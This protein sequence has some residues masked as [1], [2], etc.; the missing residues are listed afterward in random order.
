[1]MRSLYEIDP[2]PECPELVRVIVEIPKNAGNKYEYDRKLGV[3]RLD[4]ALYSPMHYPGDYGFIP[5]TLAPDGDPMDVLVMV[6][7][8][9][10][11]GCM[12]EVR[13]VGILNMIDQQASDQKILAVPNR[14]P[15]YDE[16]HTMDQIFPHVRREIEHFFTIYKELEGRVTT[17]QGWD[18][19]REARRAIQESRTAY[20][21]KQ[22]ASGSK[23]VSSD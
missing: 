1:M 21:E 16:V 20:L 2:G 8:P 15:R 19:P 7:E 13:P 3:F 17:T 5:G 11:P 6:E 22:R 4:R 9:S 10:F 12:I 14:N 23:D 18:G